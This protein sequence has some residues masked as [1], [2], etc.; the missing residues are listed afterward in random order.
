MLARNLAE[1]LLKIL[2]FVTYLALWALMPTSI[3]ESSGSK[4][5]KFCSHSP[6]AINTRGMGP[7]WPDVLRRVLPGGRGGRG[8]ALQI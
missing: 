7:S 1:S 8:G 3:M 2:I 6:G 4:V 5:V